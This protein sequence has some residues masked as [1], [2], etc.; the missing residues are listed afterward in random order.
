MRAWKC[1]TWGGPNHLKLGNVPDPECG[2]GQVEI[3]VNACGV[4]F[5]DLLLISGR[6][7]V[8]PELP[9]VPG[10]EVAGR[11][12]RVGEG[13]EMFSVGDKAAA[14]VKHGGYADRVVAPI[15]QVVKI[16]ESISFS[17]AAAFPVSY[18]SAELALDRA[19]L[20]AGEVVVIGGAAGA[21][22][23]A[24]VELVKHRGA[25]VI[26]CV[27][28]SAKEEI[29]RACGADEIVSSRSHNLKTDLQKIA[30]RVDVIID[31]I[32][33]SFFEESLQ[34]LG[35]GGRVVSL[36]FASGKIPSIRLNHFLV[37]HQSVVGSSFGLTCV[38]DPDLIS[39]KWP[40]LAEMLEA[41]QIN[42]R[43]SQIR[44]FAELPAALQLLKD[45]KVAGRIVLN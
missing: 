1:V 24:C 29:A 25:V 33:G 34:M 2:A 16:P 45:R 26:A 17:A 13:C 7:Q 31:P 37:K 27:G 19:G 36:G 3:M 18:G 32:G 42:P 44:P 15:A 41:G 20:S 12:T 6:Y 22:G 14:Y 23:T 9:F 38:K 28:D 5:A 8:R 4:N 39:A 40:Q 21:V 43:V 11:I 30:S 35:Y 10:M